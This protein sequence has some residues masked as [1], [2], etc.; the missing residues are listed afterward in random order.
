MPGTDVDMTKIKIKN[1]RSSQ[2]T[3]L[4]S[5]KTDISLEGNFIY[6]FFQVY[7]M[8]LRVTHTWKL[9][10]SDYYTSTK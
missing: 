5:D 1:Y 9:T 10:A 4:F 7:N 3:A 2:P 8:L 6:L